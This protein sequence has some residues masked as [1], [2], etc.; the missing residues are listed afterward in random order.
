MSIA[1]TSRLTRGADNNSPFFLVLEEDMAISHIT[2]ADLTA[3]D[4]VE[5]WRRIPYMTC[6]VV[7]EQKDYK[8]GADTTIIGQVWTEVDYGV[9]DDVLL[10]DDILDGDGFIKSD[11]LRNIFL[12]D[13]YVVADEAAMLALTTVTGNFV[14]QTDTSSVWIKL[15]NDDPADIGDFVEVT[16]PG[17]VLSVNGNT[18]VVTI[19]L[20]DL[21]AA[22]TSAFNAAVAAAPSVTSLSSSISTLFSSISSLEASKASTSYVNTHIL[23]NEMI[24]PA[25]DSIAWWKNSTGE[26]K[27]LKLG[28]GLSVDTDILNVTAVG[29]GGGGALDELSNVQITSPEIGDILAFTGALWVNTNPNGENLKYYGSDGSGAVGWFSLPSGGFGLLDTYDDI[30]ELLSTQGAQQSLGWYMVEDASTDTTVTSGWAI[31]QYLGTTNGDLTDYLKIGEQESLDVVLNDASTTVKGIVELADQTESE[32][33]A[34]SATSSGA[35]N[36]RATTL[37]STWW[38]WDKIKTLAQTITATWTLNDIKLAN[39]AA[40]SGTYK[41]VYVDDTGKIVKE[42]NFAINPTDKTLELTGVDQ[43]AAH[44]TLLVKDSVGNTIAKFNNDRTVELGGTFKIEVPAG[45]A[46]GAALIQF[47]GNLASALRIGDGTTDWIEFISTTGAPYVRFLKPI[48]YNQGVGFTTYRIQ[49]FISTN[50]TAGADTVVGSFPIAVSQKAT[51]KAKI[52]ASDNT[53]RTVGG[54]ILSIFKRTAAGTLSRVNES[55]SISADGGIT[56]SISLVANNTTKN[57]DI[58]FTNDS[59]TGYAYDVCVDMEIQLQTSPA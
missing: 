49:Y 38:F 53:D 42:T 17:A 26:V 58:T 31:Y 33:A 47:L 22:E 7:A 50:T 35:D 10:E 24:N 59:G 6:Y 5:E 44:Y 55:N 16:Y 13:Y 3:R 4:A 37:R 20:A 2:V 40:S 41:L 51:V 18:G 46:S 28:A 12:N 45:T 27:W 48:R 57:I 14:L 54:E 9:P 15:N 34:S 1:I 52:I 8:L 29:E 43:L 23:G 21:I 11:L 39:Q 25:T 19:T 56:A 30:A 32:T 36:T